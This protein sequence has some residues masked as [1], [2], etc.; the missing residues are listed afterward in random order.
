MRKPRNY[1]KEY[2]NYQGKPEQI[3]R[4]S[5]RNSLRRKLKLKKGDPRE[6]GHIGENRKGK[7]SRSK[8]KA[9]PFE[10]NRKDQPKRDGSQD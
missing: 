1:R 6:A 8:G 7:L 9:I 2:D 5:E 4:R 10:T 3:A